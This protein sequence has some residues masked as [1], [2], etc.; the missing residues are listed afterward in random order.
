MISFP[1]LASTTDR[2]DS[3]RKRCSTS[4][5]FQYGIPRPVQIRWPAHFENY[6]WY[7]RRTWSGLG[8]WTELCGACGCPGTR[9][10][11]CAEKIMTLCLLTDVFIEEMRG[12]YFPTVTQSFSY[13]FRVRLYLSLGFI[14]EIMN[15]I[16]AF[17]H[18]DITSVQ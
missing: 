4:R 2:V 3:Q 9:C 18:I 5:L 6:K 16:I 17:V 11:Q 10:A 1:I 8:D 13:F 12:L 14:M 15:L 7:K